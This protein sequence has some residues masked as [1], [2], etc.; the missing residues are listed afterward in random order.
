MVLG[1]PIHFRVS[2][3]IERT[4]PIIGR[5]MSISDT[6][7]PLEKYTYT[8]EEECKCQAHDIGL[9]ENKKEKTLAS[10]SKA[11]NMFGLV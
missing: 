8:T 10:S 11:L 4:G 5:S 6:R 1:F 7:G 3:L 2:P 9:V